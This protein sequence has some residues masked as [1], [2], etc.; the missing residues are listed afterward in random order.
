MRKVA[1]MIVVLGG[2]LLVSCGGAEAVPTPAP[3]SAPSSIDAK[4]LYA[5][6]CAACHGADRQGISG[7]GT[8][9][10]PERLSALN[11]DQI[12]DTIL[13][14]KPDTVMPAWKGTLSSAEIDA[15]I[16]L[17]KYTSP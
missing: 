2:L 13:N 4:A 7:V 1:L 11:D 17:I 5:T 12:K 16:Q 14:G 6:N 8:A 9:L 15:L 10:I 3:V